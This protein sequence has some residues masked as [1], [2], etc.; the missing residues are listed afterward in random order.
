MMVYVEASKGSEIVEIS[1]YTVLFRLSEHATSA[2][3]SYLKNSA[4]I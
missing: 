4:N 2:S 3:L 1:K